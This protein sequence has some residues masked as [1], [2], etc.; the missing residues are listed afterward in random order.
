MQSS[1][2]SATEMIREFANIQQA[3]SAAVKQI[4]DIAGSAVR[5]RGFCTIVLAG[6]S[7]PRQTYEFLS[8][9][10]NAA[11][12]PWQQSHFFWGD[13]RWLAS[14]HP[15]S[16]YHMAHNVLLSKVP[17][18]SRNIHR[19]TTRHKNPETAAAL[20]EKH[21]RDFFH[22]KTRAGMKSNDLNMSIP[23]F[24]LVLLG[25]GTDG[26]TA[27]L[28]PGSDLLEERKKWVAAVPPGVG[29]P[30][31]ARITLTLPLLNQA[32]N[33]IFLI[34]GNRKRAILDSI[35]TRPAEAEALYPAARIKPVGTLLWLAAAEG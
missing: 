4:T 31:V 26:H 11:K 12:M 27:S 29:S 9:A 20:Y 3:S 24:D 16:N 19:I 21:L 23:S 30:P 17:V 34:A 13:E 2:S 22:L 15:D 25:M 5:A 7:T 35:L 32:E 1:R 33:V 8:A 10:A 6:G 28:F 18:P 14:S